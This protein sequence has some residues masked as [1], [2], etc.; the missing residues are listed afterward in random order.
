MSSYRLGGTI[1]QEENKTLR[2]TVYASR[3]LTQTER[4][5]TQIE[6]ECLASVWV[7]ERSDQYIAE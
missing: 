7:C 4:N 6:K 2:V 1:F 5:Y 3:T